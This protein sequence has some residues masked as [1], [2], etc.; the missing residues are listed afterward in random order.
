MTTESLDSGPLDP[1]PP[2]SAEMRPCAS[3]TLRVNGF[4]RPVTDAWI[5]ES[6]LYVLRERLGLA[7]AKDGCEQGECGACS[8]QVDGQL[9]A[10]C[11]VPAAL[12]ADSEINTVEGL[13]AGGAASDVQQALAESGAVQ[14]GYC[15]PGMAMAVHDLLQR[16]H[17]PSEVEA[18]QAL[19]GNLCRCTGYRGVLAAV[20]TVAEARAVEA[21]QADDGSAPA[22]EGTAERPAA[23]PVATEQS[24][25]DVPLAGELPVYA[26]S[27]A[28]VEHDPQPPAAEQQP[29]QHQGHHE[30]QVHHGQP[31]HHGQPAAGP[32]GEH[33]AG[34]YGD[35]T[36]QPTA[37]GTGTGMGMAYGGHEQG[38]QPGASYDAGVYDTAVLPPVPSFPTQQGPAGQ[39]HGQGYYQQPG[40]PEGAYAGTPAH[41]AYLPG[42]PGYQEAPYEG[43]PYQVPGQQNGQQ[44]VPQ[45]GHPNGQQGVPQGAPYPGPAY[46]SGEYDTTDFEHAP[47]DGP[48]YESTPAHGTA[49]DGTGY[50]GTPAQGT[51]YI[52]TPPHGVPTDGAP[53][54][55]PYGA[56]PA[57]GIVPQPSGTSIPEDR[58]A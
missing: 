13:S 5:G 24:A 40:Y 57:H 21:E 36:G 33:H 23:A 56:D 2:V 30:H 51:P 55:V 52:P 9:V 15:T 41:G 28:W 43:M 3:Y 48:V 58:H 42:A 4:E 53:A 46:R 12:A 19:C 16:N 7:G 6:L 45:N 10:G 27:D 11:L 32:S 18:R 31:G 37:A 8:V 54:G 17:R 20:Q 26:D 34:P 22:E 47:Y 38:G 35:G 25:A 44:G 1:A 39:Q 14:C 50:D 29:V 49:F